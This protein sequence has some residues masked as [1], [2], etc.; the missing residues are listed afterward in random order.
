VTRLPAGQ[1][2]G[3]PVEGPEENVETTYLWD[4]ALPEIRWVRWPYCPEANS[5]RGRYAAADTVARSHGRVRADGTVATCERLA[6]ALLATESSM[7][8][9]RVLVAAVNV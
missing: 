7:A 3:R 8:L 4:F 6:F 9:R 5:R 1:L 2:C